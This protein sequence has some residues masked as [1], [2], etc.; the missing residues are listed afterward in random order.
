VGEEDEYT[1]GKSITEGNGGFG[2]RTV[3]SPEVAVEKVRQESGGKK[4]RGRKKEEAPERLSAPKGASLGGALLW[5]KGTNMGGAL[6]STMARVGCHVYTPGR[7]LRW[8]P[9][10]LLGCQTPCRLTVG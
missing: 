5:S 8:R 4:E 3:R 10:V 6:L 9:V 7:Q 1:L 2:G